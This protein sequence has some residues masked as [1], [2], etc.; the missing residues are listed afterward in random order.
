MSRDFDRGYTGLELRRLAFSVQHMWEPTRAIS[1]L[2]DMERHQLAE[3]TRALFTVS[4]GLLAP[5][6]ETEEKP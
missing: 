1:Y 5:S 2:T 3:L 6:P 4:A